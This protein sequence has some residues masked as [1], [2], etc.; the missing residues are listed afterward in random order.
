MSRVQSIGRVA[1][2]FAFLLVQAAHADPRVE[3]PP[4][5]LLK[6][7]LS[8]YTRLSSDGRVR[9]PVLTVIDYARPSSQRRLWVLDPG[10]RAVR[11]GNEVG[12]LRSSL[13]IF[14][15]G[16]P[17]T[18][19]HGWSLRLRGLEPGRNDRAEE[20]AIVMHPADYVSRTFRLQS[21]GRLGRS[22][23]C[24]AL[25]PA[26]APR[27]IERIRSGSVLYAGGPSS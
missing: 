21:G 14:L 7:G 4:P 13:G 10:S 6:R 5:A 23:G 17:Y 12:S 8:A 1:A 24:P 18:G 25:D 19:M 16:E 3:G 15:T 27:I 9:N 26:V 11:F 22:F 2:V 20:R